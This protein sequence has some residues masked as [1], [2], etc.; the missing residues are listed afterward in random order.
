VVKSQLRGRKHTTAK[1]AGVAVSKQDVL[2]GQGPSLLRDMT[3]GQQSDDRGHFH[4]SG[5]GMDYVVVQLF[6]LSYTL[7]QQDHSPTDG[8]DIDW[9]EGCVQYQDW[10]LHNCRFPMRERL[11]N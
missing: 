11:G 7:E 6:C 3:I 9:L 2:A 5:S 4:G 10:F 1:L 8:G